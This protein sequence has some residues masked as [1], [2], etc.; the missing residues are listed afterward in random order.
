MEAQ[1][2]IL[3]L[4]DEGDWLDVCREFLSQLPSKPEIRTVSTG[5]RALALLDSQPFRVLLCDLKMPRMDGLQVL[6]IV[7]RRFPELRTVALTGF[8]DEDFRS[9]AYALGVDM[10][11]LKSD[12]QQNQQMFLD[13]IES[14]LGQEDGGGFRDVQ[15]KNILDVIRM[16]LALRNSSVLRITS[17]RQVAQL[18][19]MDGQIID[20][21]VEG[22]D[23]EAAFGRLL[24][25]KGGMFES[26]PPENG[27]IQTIHKSLEALLTESAQTLKKTANPTRLQEEEETNFVTRMTALAYEGAEFVVTVPVKKE[28]AAKGWG[29][30]DTDRPAAWAR[31][32]EKAMQRLGQKLNAGPWTH[33]A[34]QSLERHVLLMPGNGRTFVIG[35]P[36]KTDPRQLFEQSKKLADTWAS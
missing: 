24:K 32:A 4:D 34:G 1:H 3:V 18:W 12:M 29:I 13:C 11:W 28:D 5:M 26:L 25:W 9:R 36:P 22:A 14:L 15:S 7:R 20:A 16:E 27:H 2:K 31:L 8:S 33:I 23:G 30:H 19:I 21:R 35:W 10:F 6:S 17:G